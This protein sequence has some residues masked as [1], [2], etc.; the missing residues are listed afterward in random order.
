M[1]AVPQRKPLLQVSN[2]RGYVDS[3]GQLMVKP[4]NDIKWHCSV[5]A[6]LD[7][8]ASAELRKSVKL[9]TRRKFGAFFTGSELAGKLLTHATLRKK[10]VLLHD[11]T[12]GAGDL[13]LAAAQK[14]P[15]ART[16]PET[17]RRW[18][19]QLAGHDLHQEFIDATLT[20]LVLLARQRHRYFGPLPPRWR[21]FF[22]LISRA[23]GLKDLTHCARATALIMNP[24]FGLAQAPRQCTWAEGRISQAAIFVAAALDQMKSGATLL[25]ILPEVLRSGSTYA[26]WRDCLS[27][28][29]EVHLVKSYGIFDDTADVDVFL[30]HLRRRAKSKGPLR[31]QWPGHRAKSGHVLGDFFAVHVGRVVPFR[32]AQLGPSRK[33]IHPRCVPVWTEMSRFPETRRFQGV[34]YAPPFVVIRRTSRP[35]HPYRAAATIIR[36]DQ[37]IAVEN[38]LIVC[39]PADNTLSRCRELMRNLKTKA[40]NTFLNRRIRCRHL[41]TGAVQAIPFRPTKTSKL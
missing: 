20:R 22:P 11:P 26:K 2:Y 40:V 30:L 1:S 34:I 24:P 29:A 12:C 14:L 35:G 10:N 31:K 16:F 33:Y 9:E 25:A 32:D 8:E 39:S 15:L 19:F 21:T 18:G 3:L 38:H 4:Q 7:G 13:L 17:L 28:L 23:N 5:A 27:N 41:T 37:P 6:A 36:G